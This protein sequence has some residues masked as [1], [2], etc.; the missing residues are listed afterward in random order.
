MIRPDADR[1]VLIGLSLLL[2]S[3]VGCDEATESTPPRRLL[4][5]ERSQSYRQGATVRR[6]VDAPVPSDLRETVKVPVNGRLLI[7]F[8]IQH[9]DDP[10]ERGTVEVSIAAVSEGVEDVLFRTQT[11]AQ[12]AANAWREKVVDLAGHER[13]TVELSFRARLTDPVAV[14]GPGGARVRWQL[15]VL[16]SAPQLGDRPNLIVIA[17]DTLRSD[18]L[19]SYGYE[20]NTSPAIASLASRG[21][22]FEQAFSQAPWTLPSFASLFTGLRPARHGV[23][24]KSNA[25]SDQ[26][27]TLPGTLHE[28]GYYTAGFHDGGYVSHAHGFHHA[29]DLYERVQGLRGV[30][31]VLDW[32]REHRS[33]PFFLFIHSYDVHAP[34]GSV[35]QSYRDRFA[36]KGA[37]SRFDLVNEKPA[38]IFRKLR[39]EF[40]EGDYS[41]MKELYDSEVRFVDDQLGHFFGVLDELQLSD[42]T[43]VILLSDHGE[44]FG[45]HGR[46]EHHNGNV[47]RELSQIPLVISGPGIAH[48]RRTQ[49]LVE[50]VDVLPTVLELLGIDRGAAE[51]I[52]GTSLVPL[53]YERERAGERTKR[54]AFTQT[55]DYGG[56][57]A[58][59][60]ED[61]TLIESDNHEPQLFDRR[62]DP[63]ETVDVKDAH[64]DVVELLGSTLS[65]LAAGSPRE[66]TSTGADMDEETRADL[67]A[68]GYIE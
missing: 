8:G 66:D 30:P 6:L 20:Q 38:Q 26:V 62:I 40:E 32:I 3:L 68:L 13:K 1:L 36:S 65:E 43:I 57:R 21:V 55:H 23:V 48:G 28:A 52:D 51:G 11:P 47:Y 61:W 2:G 35:P 60:T 64:P 24:N 25:L 10:T 67:R 49:E 54:Y 16:H 46:F 34:Y 18:H 4:S 31:R 42:R 15:P 53:L 39:T 22:V 56:A 37:Q 63:G 50:T 58:L 5:L 44:E 33:V 27:A 29:F 7:G 17:I 19:T 12:G 41:R 59:R 9:G 45:D 14:A